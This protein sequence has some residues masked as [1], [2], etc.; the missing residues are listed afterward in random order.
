MEGWRAW[1]ASGAH[2]ESITDDQSLQ[3][4]GIPG[5]KD[6]PLT[7]DGPNLKYGL[8]LPTSTA[9]FIKEV[10]QVRTRAAADCHTSKLII[11]TIWALDRFL[12][13]ETMLPVK[14]RQD[15][16]GYV[17]SD[18]LL[19]LAPGRMIYGN[20]LDFNVSTFTSDDGSHPNARIDLASLIIP[21][22]KSNWVLSSNVRDRKLILRSIMHRG[23]DTKVHMSLEAVAYWYGRTIGRCDVSHHISRYVL[24]M[25]S[26]FPA[27]FRRTIIYGVRFLDF[28]PSRLLG[29]PPPTPTFVRPTT[30]EEFK[31]TGYVPDTTCPRFVEI[32]HPPPPRPYHVILFYQ[33]RTGATHINVISDKISFTEELSCLNVFEQKFGALCKETT[34]FVQDPDNLTHTWLWYETLILQCMEFR[35]SDTLIL[36]HLPRA[37]EIISFIGSHGPATVEMVGH[38]VDSIGTDIAVL[39]SLRLLSNVYWNI[40]IAVQYSYTMLFN[41]PVDERAKRAW[42]SLGYRTWHIRRIPKQNLPWIFWIACRQLNRLLAGWQMGRATS[43]AS[44]NLFWS[45]SRGD[46]VP[47][48]RGFS[49]VIPS[50]HARCGMIGTVMAWK[51]LRKTMS[52]PTHSISTYHPNPCKPQFPS[53]V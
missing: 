7:I 39:E 5:S 51:V 26:R 41:F 25:Y 30:P 44:K 15:K 35:Q 48:L 4:S 31:V 33:R 12:P 17:T 8:L 2:E 32:L 10:Q 50:S 53:Y 14:V 49:I 18:A 13:G 45:L 29:V 22:I 37:R 43:T 38:G 47:D 9:T 42:F 24:H 27:S 6:T 3:D 21:R 40:Q 11:R 20:T 36:E 1:A 28:R 52:P 23:D 16:D 46:H 34:C 19:S